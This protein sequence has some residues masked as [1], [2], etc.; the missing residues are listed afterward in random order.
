MRTMAVV[1]KGDFIRRWSLE[2]WDFLWISYGFMVFFGVCWRRPSDK[3]KFEG[4]KGF[5][6]PQDRTQ[7]N[8]LSL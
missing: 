7:L 3:P 1:A 4:K 5:E 2:P 8:S 6:K